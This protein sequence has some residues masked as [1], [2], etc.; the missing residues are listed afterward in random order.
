MNCVAMEEVVEPRSVDD[1]C[2]DGA[3]VGLR[4]CRVVGSLT[5]TVV[6]FVEGIIVG[7]CVRRSTALSMDT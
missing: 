1:G 3:I 6:G 7:G 2:E 5:D 4:L